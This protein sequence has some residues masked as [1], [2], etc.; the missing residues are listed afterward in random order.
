MKGNEYAKATQR[1]P[2]YT[3]EAR[4]AEGAQPVPYLIIYFKQYQC[5]RP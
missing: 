5:A 4:A 2:Q 1:V 3:A